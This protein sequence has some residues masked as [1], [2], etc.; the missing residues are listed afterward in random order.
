[1][2]RRLCC[3]ALLSRCAAQHPLAVSAGGLR[4]CTML[5]LAD[6]HLGDDGLQSLVGAAASGSGLGRLSELTLGAF[7]NAAWQQDVRS[8]GELAPMAPRLEELL[9]ASPRPR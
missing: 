1:M 2:M 4:R 3:C 7:P 9:D 8:A 5:N 6:N